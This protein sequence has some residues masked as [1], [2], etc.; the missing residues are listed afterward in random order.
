MVRSSVRE[1][2]LQKPGLGEDGFDN[3]TADIGQTKIAAL[4]AISQLFVIDTQ[5]AEHGRVQIVTIERIDGPPGPFIAFPIARA[6]L[7]PGAGQPRDRRA[8]VMVAA[9]RLISYNRRP[10]ATLWSTPAASSPLTPMSSR[11]GFM[12]STRWSGSRPKRHF[13]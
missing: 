7:D 10:C 4:R 3:F 5:E 1:D 8:T 13:R 2:I 6:T 12:M 9:L 11:A